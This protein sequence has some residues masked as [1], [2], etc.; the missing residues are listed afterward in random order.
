MGRY[1]CSQI[2]IENDRS[3]PTNI[4][5][6]ITYL[7]FSSWSIIIIYLNYYYIMIYHCQDIDISPLSIN[8]SNEIPICSV[9]DLSIHLSTYLSIYQP[10]DPSIP[11]SIYPHISL[12]IYLSIDRSIYLSTYLPI[13]LP[14]YLSIYLSI[15]IFLFSPG[16]IIR[17]LHLRSSLSWLNGKT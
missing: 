11:P 8:D 16:I 13:Y 9:S 14:I 3:M 6:I 4:I 17:F 10:I 1:V 12:S 15:S 2:V 7:P 5:D